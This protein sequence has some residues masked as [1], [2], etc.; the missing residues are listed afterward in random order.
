MRSGLFSYF[1]AALFTLF[2]PQLPALAQS[3]EKLSLRDAIEQALAS[4]LNLQLQQ[5]D[6]QVAEG[7][8]LAAE[9]K[10]DFFI[11]AETLAR[12]EELAPLSPLASEREDTAAWNGAVSK[13][14][15]TGT[16]LSLGYDN[17]RLDSDN[18]LLDFNPSY[19]SALVFG[20][21]QP[22]L[23]GFGTEVQTATLRESQ[24]RL[25]ATVFQVDSEAANLA[26][27]VK[28]AYWRFYFALQNIEVQKLS[29]TLARKL[30]EE[31]EAKIDA[32][33]LA[34]IDFFQPQ[35]EVARREEQLITAER[36]VGTAE[37]SLKLLLNSQD[38]LA[39]YEPTDKPAIK[40]VELH[41]PT[42][43]D[44]ALQHRPDIK[45]ADLIVQ[46]AKIQ[47]EKAKDDIRPDLSL[48]GNVGVSG[49]DRTYGDAIDNS[50]SD[51]ENLW[52]I[53]LNFSVPLENSTAKGLHQQAKA[54]YSKARTS[55]ELLRQQIRRTVRTTIRDVELAIKA[56]DATQ[57]TSLATQKRLEA[58]QAK[59]LSGRATTL[60]VLASQ[61]AYSEA[62]S[63]ENLTI[64]TYANSLAELDRIQ[65][66]VTFSSSR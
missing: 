58:E 16:T 39:E 3:V 60:D 25:E 4:N 5:Q 46:A 55:A 15:T 22:L 2:L 27:Q 64:V 63:Q 47:E 62:L 18:I 45:A 1:I 51:P 11:E 19:N 40:P 66:L 21:T 42:I 34:P 65:G 17:S 52:L 57:K 8:R 12:N 61:Q 31:T 7:A 32:G 24:K 29:L 49:T 13:K 35:S 59:F 33:K 37:D 43:L 6:V 36:A 9:G 48:I 28:V 56:I 26:A 30:L 53:G 14:F 20:M 50:V 10:F 23:K 38:W 44:N 54:N 41:L